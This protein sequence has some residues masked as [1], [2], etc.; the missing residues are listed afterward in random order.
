MY[1]GKVTDNNTLTPENSVS[2]DIGF[3]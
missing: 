3:K 2:T 1:F